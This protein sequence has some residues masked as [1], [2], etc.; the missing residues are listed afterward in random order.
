MFVPSFISVFCCG[1]MDKSKQW[2]ENYK[3]SSYRNIHAGLVF[4]SKLNQ[5]GEVIIVQLWV[6]ESTP[7]YHHCTQPAGMPTS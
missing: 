3:L 7:L 2:A 4:L 5:G 1:K 6:G